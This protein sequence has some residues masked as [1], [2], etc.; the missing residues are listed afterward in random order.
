MCGETRMWDL[1]WMRT[2]C[3]EV[4][5]ARCGGR[6][7]ATWMGIWPERAGNREQET[8]KREQERGNREVREQETGSREQGTGNREV[9]S[10]KL[11]PG[12][13]Y[14]D[15]AWGRRRKLRLSG[16]SRRLRRRCFL[17]CV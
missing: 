15:S 17:V 3:C 11:L 13:I 10:F 1:G 8:G 5:R 14:L 12:R 4:V 9:G 2:R 6:I 7:R 16:G